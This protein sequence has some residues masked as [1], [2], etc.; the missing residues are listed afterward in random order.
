VHASQILCYPAS[1]PA[2]SDAPAELSCLEFM[3]RS[4]RP[5]G[6]RRLVVAVVAL[7]TTLA[8]LHRRGVGAVCEVEGR[9]GL[10]GF[11]TQ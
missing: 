8:P 7:L 4:A 1:F 3:P 11:S 9:S 5:I 2:A 6:L 10:Y